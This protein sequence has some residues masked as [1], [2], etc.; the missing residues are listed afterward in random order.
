[1]NKGRREG[2]GERA[3]NN[4]EFSYVFVWCLFR[5]LI[6]PKSGQNPKKKKH[7]NLQPH[8]LFCFLFFSFIFFALLSFSLLVVLFLCLVKEMEDAREEV[9]DDLLRH[10]AKGEKGSLPSPSLFLPHPSD[11]FFLLVPDALWHAYAFSFG[12]DGAVAMR[13]VDSRCVFC[14]VGKESSRIVFEVYFP[15]LFSFSSLSHRSSPTHQVKADQVAALGRWFVL[16]NGFCSCHLTNQLLNHK[17]STTTITAT[18]TTTATNKESLSRG[19]ADPP[20]CAHRLAVKIA[21]VLKTCEKKVVE[22]SQL[23]SFLLHLHEVYF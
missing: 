5:S 15:F 14:Y 6:G 13:L 19:G 18:T 1:M 17:T 23:S 22:E 11:V 7:P 4:K 16:P 3:N 8:F 2:Q 9:I 20:L 21:T 10:L 12:E